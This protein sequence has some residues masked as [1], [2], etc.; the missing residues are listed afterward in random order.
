MRRRDVAGGDVAGH[1]PQVGLRL[2]QLGGVLRR[3]TRAAC[4]TQRRASVR[5]NAAPAGSTCRTTPLASS[6]EDAL[7]L[8]GVRD[9]AL[10]PSR[11]V[12]AP[13][14]TTRRTSWPS[15]TV[16]AAQVSS[17]TP[18]PSSWGD[19]DDDHQQPAVAVAL[20]EVL[21]DHAS[22]EQAEAGRDLGHPLLGGRPAGAERDHVGRLDAGAGRGAAD[23]GAA[24][25]GARRSAS[26]NGV[27][28]MIAD[29]LSWLPPVMKMPVASSSSGDQ[30][31]VVRPRSRLSGRTPTTSPAPSLRNSASYTSTTSS[32]RLDAVGITAIRASAPPLA[33]T[34][35]L[36]DGAL[37]ELVLG[38]ADD[39]QRAARECGGRLDARRPGCL[40]G[41]LGHDREG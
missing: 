16:T 5:S 20:V 13:R 14:P 23:D 10:R 26:P 22:C 41:E 12:T 33:A 24:L 27:P 6:G 3:T 32:P 35:S 19:C 8:V 36:E 37:A 30:V 1:L 2:G 40:V 25:V 15:S 21:V 7:G 34:K 38:A 17:S 4:G 28:Q 18:I 31:G 39:H 11:I 9:H 29:S